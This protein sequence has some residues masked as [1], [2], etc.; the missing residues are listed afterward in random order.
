MSDTIRERLLSMKDGEYADFQRKLMPTVRPES[1]IG[2]RTPALRAFAKEIACTAQAEAF[3]NELPHKYYD[4]NNL[5]AMLIE[6]I[7]PF[8]EAVARVEAFL[9]YVDNWATC[10]ILKPRA[11][12]KDLPALTERIKVWV[13]SGKTYT[14]RFGIE[15]LMNFFLDS[16]F[17]PEQLE[18][19]AAV[20]SSEY[21]VNMMRAWY[22]ATAL[23]KQREAT[24]PMI[25]G[26][27]LDAWTHNKTIQKAVE[28]YRISDDDKAL[29]RT[30][31]V[32]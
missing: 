29:L 15:M 20:E 8:D 22:F 7:K 12:K 18:T 19:V 6:K 2:V 27:S 30:M 21:Y 10:D 11:F 25:E 1:V 13:A 32:K 24:L 5:H 26:M 16:E 4:E 14:V 23:A 31:R 17:M 9:P 28:S 3:L